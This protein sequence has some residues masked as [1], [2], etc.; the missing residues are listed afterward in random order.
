MGSLYTALASFLDARHHLGSWQLR[1][2]DIDPPRSV[3]GSIERI[4]ASLKAHGLLWDGEVVYQSQSADTFEH[5]L[6]RLW[7]SGSLFRCRCTRAD[8]KTTGSC[9]QACL[10]QQH[11]DDAPH[12]LR[13][14]VDRSLLADFEDCFLG[15]Q[16][17]TPEALPQDF[18][19]KRRDGLFA[20]QLAAA[21][22]DAQPSFT[23]IV[24]GKDLLDSTHRQRYLQSVLG[25]SSPQ[26]AHVALLC[27]ADGNKLSKQNG[28]PEVNLDQAADNL[29]Q[30]LVQLRQAPP[31]ASAR[32]P[33]AILEHAVTHWAPP[34]HPT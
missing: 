11:A 24:R 22:D 7:Q 12:S 19:V 26:Y 20:Y 23:H 25:L 6:T 27:G 2:D 34:R 29:R 15:P 21:I 32:N 33:D 4:L 8:L 5:A 16:D 1:I 28:A 10:N 13:V 14:S 9:G 18:I 3:A 17:I 31:P 30:C